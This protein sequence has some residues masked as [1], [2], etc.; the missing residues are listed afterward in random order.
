MYKIMNIG[1]PKYL[2]DL[3]PKRE[4][5]Y[6][7]RN[8]NK[9]LFNGRTES[10]INFQLLNSN[11]LKVF[12]SN[13]LAFIRPVQRSIYKAFN[14]QGLKSLIRLRRGFFHLNEHRFRHNF[15][16]C[17]NPLCSCSLKVE[18][19]LHFFLQCHHYSTFHMCL[20]NKV[21][22]IDENFSHLSDDNKVNLLLYG[23]SRFDDN[24]ILY[25]SITYI[26]DTQRFL[27]SLFQSNV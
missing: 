27:T 11:L 6:N 22:Q 15:K 9:S 7:I 4:I 24:F 21:N 17:L 14:Y 20:M 18:K 16:D 26:L 13:L 2:T 19:T 10:F 8:R 5:G 12:K 1:I 23:D 3:I 25:T